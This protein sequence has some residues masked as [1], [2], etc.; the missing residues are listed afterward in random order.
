MQLYRDI[1]YITQEQYENVDKECKD[2]GADLPETCTKLLDD[3]FLHL[4]RST[5]S[6]MGSTSTM[7]TD[8]ATKTTNSTV[9][10]LE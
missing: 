1:G 9:K 10:N 6:L 4:R 2:Q 5:T 8:P 7:L 3:V